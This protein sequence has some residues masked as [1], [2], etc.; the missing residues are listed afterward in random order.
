MKKIILGAVISS[1]CF[2]NTTYATNLM[3]N[4]ISFNGVKLFD[5]MD[6]VQRNMNIKGGVLKDSA[7]CFR[8]NKILGSDELCEYS[9]FQAIFHDNVLHAI[10]VMNQNVKTPE[11]LTIG[12]NMSDF[13][14]VYGKPDSSDGNTHLYRIVVDPIKYKTGELS[15]TTSGNVITRI[16]VS[17]G[18]HR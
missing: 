10:L 13:I 5:T 9:G 4:Q 16:L 17:D 1:L 8:V 11:G 7:D 6:A 3:Y 18:I 2:I 12:S 15:V 14:S